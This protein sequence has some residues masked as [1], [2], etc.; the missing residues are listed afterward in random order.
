MHQPAQ[1]GLVL[2]RLLGFAGDAG[3]DRVDLGQLGAGLRHGGLL[4]LSFTL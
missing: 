4:R 1:Q 3:P 2:H